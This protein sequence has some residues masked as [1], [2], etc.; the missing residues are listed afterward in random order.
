MLWGRGLCTVWSLV[1][2]RSGTLVTQCENYSII[3]AFCPKIR[4]IREEVC[5]P[6]SHLKLRG[7]PHWLVSLSL[8]QPDKN[9]CKAG[10]SNRVIWKAQQ[11]RRWS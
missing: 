5:S 2:Q 6:E 9:K 11:R 1:E 10:W 4:N 7:P 8:G 3:R